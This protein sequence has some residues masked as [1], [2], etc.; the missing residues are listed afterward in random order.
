[1]GRSTL[2]PRVSRLLHMLLAVEG[3]KKQ[4]QGLREQKKAQAREALERAALE[5]FIKKG[6]DETTIKE[7]AEAAGVSPRTFFRYFASKE[8]VVFSRPEEEFEALRSLLAQQLASKNPFPALKAAG[9]E[10]ATHLEQQQD[11]IRLRAI[12]VSQ[13][14]SLQRRAAL[15]VQAWVQRLAEELAAASGE[16]PGPHHLLVASSVVTAVQLAAVA[17]ANGGAGSI[18]ENL[19][20]LLGELRTA[21]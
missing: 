6:F 18:A 13:S 11:E 1:V 17:W 8:D 21:L 2:R 5:L 10:Y 19:E 4:V 12:L 20:M 7:I 14:I 16:Q 3:D 15:E 9:F